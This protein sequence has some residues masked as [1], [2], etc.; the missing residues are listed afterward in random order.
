MNRKGWISGLGPLTI[1]ALMFAASGAMRFGQGVGAALA[2]QASPT[3]E[4]SAPPL[5]CP[6]PPERLAE[7]LRLRDAEITAREVA[8]RERLAALSL[9]EKA[10]D[11]R[12]AA[13][14]QAE[15]SLKE[16]LTIADGAA[17]NDL[18]RLTAVYEAMKPGEA[19]ALFETMAPEFA[20][21]FLGRMR[22]EAAAAVL[23]GMK[24]ETAYSISVLVAGRNA[25]APKE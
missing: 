2:L 5:N 10:I 7:A 12:L 19:A 1:L 23:S 25:L 16:T 24:P 9:S 14:A 21:G 11:A 18:A 4:P 8:L 17:E 13:L 3:T 20:A 22:P 6:E 15:A